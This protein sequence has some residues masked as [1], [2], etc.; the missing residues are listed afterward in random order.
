MDDSPFFTCCFVKQL[1][2]SVF[3]IV[4]LWKKFNRIFYLY[5]AKSELPGKKT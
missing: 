4:V 2:Q 3:I 5:I 1:I